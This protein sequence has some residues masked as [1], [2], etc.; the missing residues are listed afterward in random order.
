MRALSG[1]ICVSRLD[2]ATGSKVGPCSGRG[3]CSRLRLCTLE[4]EAELRGAE[5]ESL[6]SFSQILEA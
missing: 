4:A 3:D 6:A 5:T 2:R 1:A